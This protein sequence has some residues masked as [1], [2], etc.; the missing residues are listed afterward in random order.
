MGDY[1]GSNSEREGPYCFRF[2]LDQLNPRPNQK[3]MLDIKSS[4]DN[5]GYVIIPGLITPEQQNQLRDASAT[6]VKQTR[7]GQWP[8]RRVVGRQF[9]P[10]G[11]SE[12]DY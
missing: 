2:C 4:F 12:L 9:P 8:H 5:D 3:A 1:I 10:Y 6:V 11:D 7:A